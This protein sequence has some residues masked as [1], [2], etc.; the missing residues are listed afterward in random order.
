[1]T[2]P[3]GGRC[4]TSL[5][6]TVA[7]AAPPQAAWFGVSKP[8]PTTIAGFGARG[9][10][11]QV[12]CTEAMSGTATLNVSSAT[13][14]ALQAQV[15]DARARHRP[16][17]GR[18]LDEGDAETVEGG[19][20]RA[21]GKPPRRDGDPAG[22]PAH[23]RVSARPRARARS[24]L[25]GGDSR[26][27]GRLWSSRPPAPAG[28]LIDMGPADEYRY[29]LLRHIRGTSTHPR[30]SRGRAT[31][32]LASLVTASLSYRVRP[33]ASTAAPHQSDRPFVTEPLWLSC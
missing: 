21:G 27:G 31:S 5:P 23:D 17:H 12:T 26:A 28:T 4:R 32:C 6:R 11:V 3:H 33:E 7:P 18:R 1:M 10:S 9:V 30:C 20:A 16:L 19:P 13:R 14:K 25:R 2:A 8:A 29:A 15:G 22:A 24:R